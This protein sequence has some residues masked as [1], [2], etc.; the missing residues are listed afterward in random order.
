MGDIAEQK[1]TE[2]ADDEEEDMIFVHGRSLISPGK[3]VPRSSC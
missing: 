2:K 3:Q 1:T